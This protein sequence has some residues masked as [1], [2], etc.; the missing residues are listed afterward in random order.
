MENKKRRPKY[1]LFTIT[2]ILTIFVLALGATFSYYGIVASQEKDSTRV[3]SGS[4]SINYKDGNI[5]SQTLFPISEPNLNTTDYLYRNNFTVS[6]TSTIDQLISINL[7][8]TTNEFVTNSLKFALYDTDTGEKISDGPILTI[9]TVSVANSLSFPQ[10]G[11]KNYTLLIWLQETDTNQDKDR[12]K[13][14]VGT[15]HINSVQAKY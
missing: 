1:L 4:L 12:D 7:E 6:S 8:I 15:I 2:T 5:I 9:G 14:L 3:Y 11:L 10:V 13:L